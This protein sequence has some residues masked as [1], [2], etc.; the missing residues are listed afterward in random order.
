MASIYPSLLSA[1]IKQDI[2]LALS[3]LGFLYFYH[4]T[5][6]P[7]VLP[8]LLLPLY[9]FV[10]GQSLLDRHLVTT[11]EFN[12]FKERK[13]STKNIILRLFRTLK[14]LRTKLV[15]FFYIKLNQSLIEDI[16]LKIIRRPSVLYRRVILQGN[17][18]TEWVVSESCSGL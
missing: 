10:F 13:D 12:A 2:L 4:E 7:N 18:S 14:Y 1:H 8:C 3:K 16:Q 9:L 15:V 6:Q 5:L 17:Q 11:Q